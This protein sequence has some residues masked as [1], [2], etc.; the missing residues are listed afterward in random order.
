[1]AV[2]TGEVADN[3]SG[4]GSAVLSVTLPEGATDFSFDGINLVAVNYDENGEPTID[5]DAIGSGLG[6][7]AQSY[8]DGGLTLTVQITSESSTQDWLVVASYS[9]CSDGDCGGDPHICTLDNVHYD[10]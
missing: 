6:V 2:V 1:M 9:Y 5:E 8:S 10:L 7:G 3:G 4:P